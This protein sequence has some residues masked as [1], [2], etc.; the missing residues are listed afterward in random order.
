MNNNRLAV[1]GLASVMGFGCAVP[2]APSKVVRADM[3]ARDS[4]VL[5]PP[6]GR[7]L[8]RKVLIQ[9]FSNETTYG[10]SILLGQDVMGKQA[11]DIMSA[12]LASSQKFLLFDEEVNAAAV[13]QAEP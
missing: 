1:V 13:G 7:F 11:S 9:R 2:S 8:K 6:V 4:G 12:R 10:K 3:I 5:A